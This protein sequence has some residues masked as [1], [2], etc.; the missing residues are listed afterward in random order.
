MEP[1]RPI[2]KLL[3]AFAK[4][5]REQGGAPL[6]LHPATRRLLQGEIARRGGKAGPGKKISRFFGLIRPGFAYGACVVAVVAIGAALLLPALSRSKSKAQLASRQAK[7]LELAED[8]NQP[9]ATPTASTSPPESPPPPAFKP[10]APTPARIAESDSNVRTGPFDRAKLETAS[11][12]QPS[13]AKQSAGSGSAFSSANGLVPTNAPM[14]ASDALSLKGD[15][16]GFAG[17]SNLTIAIAADKTAGTGQRIDSLDIP[18]DKAAELSGGAGGRSGGGS[19]GGIS[20]DS[21]VV[22]Q[23]KY[24]RVAGDSPTAGPVSEA[25]PTLATFTVEQNGREMWIVDRDGAVYRGYV[26]PGSAPTTGRPLAAG[27][28]S[29]VP[30]APPSPDEERDKKTTSEMN[31]SFYFRVSGTN[32][33]NQSIV[34]S[35][36]FFIPTNGISFAPETNRAV[37]LSGE[38]RA[39]PGSSS[40]LNL[41]LRGTALIDNTRAVE[42]QAAPVPQ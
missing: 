34:F 16:N 10:P 4:K 42:I 40:L 28:N 22:V 41:H 13:L 3:R 26:L 32:R 19:D 8:R 29:S 6:E 23:Q 35:G 27:K 38:L 30:G 33:L 36:N 25:A 9:G 17:N 1:E 24:V 2:E 7:T 12:A 18:G 11:G 5:R 20:H 15:S 21:T 14:I 39:I 37:V 31:W